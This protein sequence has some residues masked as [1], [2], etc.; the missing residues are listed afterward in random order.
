MMSLASVGDDFDTAG[1]ASEADGGG[2]GGCDGASCSPETDSHV[3]PLRG[4][5]PPLP[6]LGWKSFRF[7]ELNDRH[8][9]QNIHNKEL[10][11]KIVPTMGLAD[12]LRPFE[13]PKRTVRRKKAYRSGSSLIAFTDRFGMDKAMPP[14]VTAVSGPLPRLIALNGRLYINHC[15]SAA[16]FGFFL[17]ASI[18]V[19]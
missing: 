1:V 11:R 9:L 2:T 16:D 10:S 4:G 12:R 14:K 19:G 17:L 13:H 3:W 7:N 5:T 18:L 8:R 6:Y 15:Q